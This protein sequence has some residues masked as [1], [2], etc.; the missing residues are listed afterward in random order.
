MQSKR[1]PQECYTPVYKMLPGLKCSFWNTRS[2]HKNIKNDSTS[3]IPCASD[4]MC[5]AETRL[6]KTEN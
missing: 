3:H 4:I 6:F 5:L 1:Q 2:L